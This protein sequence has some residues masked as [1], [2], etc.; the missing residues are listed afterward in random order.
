MSACFAFRK[1]PFLI[2]F[3]QLNVAV[4]MAVNVHE[5]GASNKERIFMDP[6]VLPLRDTWQ[7][8][9]FLPQ[10]LM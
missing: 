9:N 6:R 2:S 3:R 7:F 1:H 5:H 4:T 8:E 10:F